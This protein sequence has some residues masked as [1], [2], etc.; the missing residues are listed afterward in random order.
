MI[1]TDP[2]TTGVSSFTYG[3]TYG[4][5]GILGRT[6]LIFDSTSRAFLAY[7]QS[8]SSVPEPSTILLLCTGQFGLGAFRKK[9]KR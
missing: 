3:Y 4:V 8:G 1:A 6:S 9:L 7:E 2:F 5:S